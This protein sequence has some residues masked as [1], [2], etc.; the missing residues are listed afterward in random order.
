MA[1]A[2]CWLPDQDLEVAGEL[3][4][5][6]VA[7]GR[8]EYSFFPLDKGHHVTQG[9]AIVTSMPLNL[10]DPKALQP[11]KEREGWGEDEGEG[12]LKLWFLKSPGPTDKHSLTSWAFKFFSFFK[13]SGP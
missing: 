8:Q 11:G 3:G 13:Q 7:T 9:L 6:R 4:R 10:L 12:R 2:Q 5:S 1:I